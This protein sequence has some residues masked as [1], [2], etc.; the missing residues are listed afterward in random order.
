MCFENT[1]SKCWGTPDVK[2]A[3]ETSA[4]RPLNKGR[5]RTV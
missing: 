5:K 4:S 1:V 3:S 2:L